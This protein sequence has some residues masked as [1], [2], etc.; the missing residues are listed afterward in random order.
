MINADVPQRLLDFIAGFVS[1]Q[2]TFLLLLLLFLLVLGA[3]LDIFSAIVL[4]VP[5]IL[6]AV[7]SG[8]S[9]TLTATY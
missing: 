1:N 2:T 9:V 3:I 8:F 6:P 4:V 7:S 5:L